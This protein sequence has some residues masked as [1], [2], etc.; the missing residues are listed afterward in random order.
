MNAVQTGAGGVGNSET[1]AV[2]LEEI[3]SHLGMISNTL[4]SLE[5]RVS[6]NENSVQQVM[7]MHEEY[8]QSKTRNSE[9]MY[10]MQQT[11]LLQDMKDQRDALCTLHSVANQV[12]NVVEQ[13]RETMGGPA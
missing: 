12:G 10:N 7:R 6:S 1:L 2:R 8:K 13:A 9:Y 11:G 3:V 4:I 5:Q